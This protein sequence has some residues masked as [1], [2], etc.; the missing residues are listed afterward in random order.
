MVARRSHKPKVVGSSPAPAIDEIGG[1]SFVYHV[2]TGKRLG[3][4]LASNRDFVF[5]SEQWRHRETITTDRASL[6][7]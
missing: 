6:K 1:G 3:V 4:V 5:V 7:K 2:R